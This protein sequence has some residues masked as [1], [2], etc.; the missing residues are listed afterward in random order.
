MLLFRHAN[1]DDLQDILDIYNDVILKSIATFD[2]N[3]KNLQEQKCCFLEH[4]LKNPII[5]VE[6]NGIVVGW[7]ALSKWSDRCAY[8]DTA[9]I[10]LYVREKYQNLGIGKKLLKEII[11]EGEK[12]GLHT[13][14][15]RIT[16]GNQKSIKLHESIGFE[17]IGIM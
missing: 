16:D 11:K 10:S 13:V 8:S 6:E 2:K 9:E 17:H 5:V 14:I 7:A 15:A 1:L 4:G 12:V 3:T